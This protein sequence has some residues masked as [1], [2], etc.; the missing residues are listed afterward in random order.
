MLF[1]TLNAALLIGFAPSLK[2]AT[3]WTGGASTTDWNT[4]GNWDNGLPS[5][6]NQPVTIAADGANVTMSAAGVSRSLTVS[7][8][9]TTAPILN[10]TQNLSNNFSQ[11]TI[12]SSSADSNN[13]SGTVNHTSGTLLIGGGSGMRRL[14]IAASA[15]V[16]VSGNN[17]AYSFGGILATAPILS[18]TDGF[19]IGRRPGESGTLSLSGYGTIS[20]ASTSV[21]SQLNGSSI[22]NVTGGNHSINLATGISPGTTGFSMANSGGGLAIINATID[23]T[24]FSTI[25][26]GGDVDFGGNNLTRT[27]F[28]LSLDN[29]APTVGSTFT[30]LSATGNFVGT[31]GRFGNVANDDILTVDGID[32]RANYNTGIGNDIFS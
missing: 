3:I 16:S 19:S 10:I 25:N 29:F 21:M 14:I 13:F 8:N 24:G 20:T 9:G 7:G 2:A 28:N 18:V 31:Q 17:G 15:G 30:I 6:S 26:I 1:C 5:D 12:G 4:P 11:V 22:L 32:F 23:S 27:Q